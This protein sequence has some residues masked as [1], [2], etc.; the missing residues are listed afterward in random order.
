MGFYIRCNTHSHS[1]ADDNWASQQE[2]APYGPWILY[3][4]LIDGCNLILD[5]VALP[6]KDQ[7]RSLGILLDSGL[8]LDQQVARGAFL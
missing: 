6:Q 8:L 7:I 3:F 5:G 4:L 1:V 2:W